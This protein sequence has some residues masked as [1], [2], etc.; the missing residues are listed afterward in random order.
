MKRRES[1]LKQRYAPDYFGYRPKP[2][3]RQDT[4]MYSHIQGQYDKQETI[5]KIRFEERRRGW[6]E[7]NAKLGREG[8]ED[9]GNKE[10]P[11]DPRKSEIMMMLDENRISLLEGETGCGKSTQLA[12]YALEMGYD[13][14]VYLQ[15]RRVTVDNIAERI[16]EELTEQFAQKG[17][18]KPDDLV[19]MAHSERTT[20]TE[21]SAIQVM[22]SAVFKKRGPELQEAWQ[23]KK[24][25][26]VADEIHEGNIET[27]FAVGMSAEM[28]T[29]QPNWNMTLMSATMDKA[30][31]QRAYQSINEGAIPSVKVEG[32]PHNIE[33]NEVSDKN[34]VEVFSEECYE[35]ANKTLIFTE[36]KRAMGA[37]ENELRRQHPDLNVLKLHSKISEEERQAIFHAK[38][39]SGKTVI[40]STSAGQSGL[41]IR[42]VD[43]VISDGMTKSP[44]LDD[45]RASGL[46]S[47]LCSKAELTQQMGRGGRDIAGAKF[48]L[49]NQ[50]PFKRGGEEIDPEDFVP[51]ENRIDHAPAD[52]YHTI[53]TRNVLSAAAM[54]RDFYNLNE[55]LINSVDASTI[56]EAYRVLHMLGAVDRNNDVTG[57]GREMDKFPLRPELSRALV[58]I[59][60]TGSKE[61]QVRMAAIV[62]AF[63]AGGLGD[64]DPRKIEANYDKLPHWAK[65]DFTAELAYMRDYFE[66]YG[67]GAEEDWRSTSPQE[68]DAA[69]P[70]LPTPIKDARYA[71]D[72]HNSKRARKQFRKIARRMKV[73]N[74]TDMLLEHEP[75]GEEIEELQNAIVRGMPHLLYD[76]VSRSAQRGRRK[77]LPNG[78]KQQRKA[79]VKYRN[80]MVETED[81]RLGYDFD[82]EVSKRSRLA[83]SA[84]EKSALIAGYPRWY[85]DDNEQRHNVI[86]KGLVIDKGRMERALGNAALDAQQQTELGPDGRLRAVTH[87]KIG[88][89]LVNKTEA[90]AKAD[91]DQRVEKLYKAALE[92]AGPAQRELRQTRKELKRL[93][94][95][96]PHEYRPY[97][98]EKP[99]PT[100]TECN[101][102]VRKAA[103][104][105]A[106]KGELDS[107]L[108]NMMFEDSMYL[109]AILPQEMQEAIHK[110]M[111][112]ALQ[113]G[114]EWFDV[115]YIE[116]KNGGKFPAVVPRIANFPLEYA[117]ELPDRV[118]IPD[119]REVKFHYRYDAETEATLTASELKRIARQ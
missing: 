80:M 52:I 82:R 61:Q 21:D 36:G 107:K 12:Q 15:P 42:G 81:A 25:L 94:S 73:D 90:R 88:R 106:S 33:Y 74:Y 35:D 86:E 91:T 116:H 37:I 55:Y 72:W 111:P 65:D 118:T 92:D 64:G 4:G 89:L 98:Q 10:L 104:G 34:V 28:M 40:I 24:V 7:Q 14:I 78:E 119:G 93:L 30:P 39:T 63:E 20:M 53:I 1:P 16:D 18:E 95:R 41:T 31:I 47:R 109:N 83:R 11:I 117:H 5:N 29:E 59:L 103:E 66:T 27:E 9:F 6:R 108:R 54:E 8:W 38:K 22:T 70:M 48:F 115:D 100:E 112:E 77:T 96:V 69:Q 79:I 67:D 43:R 23:D 50:L 113:I 76:E 101:D 87:R 57:V 13:H 45:E 105:S 49:A 84:I 51:M 3:Q 44:E 62:A 60:H 99:I 68:T 97:Y 56:E 102:M 58:E 75:I 110:T 71:F 17:L 85:D 114:N 26:I 19:G 2:A 46:P 32:R